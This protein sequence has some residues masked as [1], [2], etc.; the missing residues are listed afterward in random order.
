MRSPSA[1][2]EA[3]AGIITDGR[4]FGHHADIAPLCFFYECFPITQ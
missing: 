3:V 1:S 4:K 2:N